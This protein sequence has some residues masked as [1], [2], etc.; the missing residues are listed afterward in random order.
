MEKG[1]KDIENYF[2]SVA[3]QNEKVEKQVKVKQKRQVDYSKRIRH[4]N[5]KLKGKDAK[6][7]ELFAQLTVLREKVSKLEE[8]NRELAKFRENRELLEKY[9]EQIETLKKEVATLKAD[10]VEKERKIEALQSSEM[11]KSRVELFIEVALNSVA[12]SVALKN[13]MKILFSKRFRKDI[14]KEISCRPFLFEN[15]ISALSR[16]ET[17]SRLLR[18]DKQEIYRIRVTSPY[19]EYRAIYTKLDKDTVKFQRFGQRDSI[20]SELDA[21]GWSFD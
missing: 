7:K 20:Y 12:S 14:V 17:T 19:G 4:L 13:G 8:E 1:F 16:C 2:L 18:R 15:F 3:Q 11:P 9:K 5:E 6:I 21:C 10:I